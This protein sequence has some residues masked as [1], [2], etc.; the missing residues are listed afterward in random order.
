MSLI[1][2][3][4]FLPFTI[5]RLALGLV[6]FIVLAVIVSFALSGLLAVA[7]VMVLL[8]LLGGAVVVTRHT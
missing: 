3:I 5:L 8:G 7:G 4:L 6:V 1:R 2:A